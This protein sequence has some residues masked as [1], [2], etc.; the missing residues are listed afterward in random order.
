M[1]IHFITMVLRGKLAMVG[2]AGL[3]PLLVNK[4][5]KK[6]KKLYKTQTTALFRTG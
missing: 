6:K 3:L 5:K 1:H 2:L 4:K